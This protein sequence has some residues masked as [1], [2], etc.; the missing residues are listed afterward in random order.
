MREI[1]ND[2]RFN[3]QYCDDMIKKINHC[4]L[5]NYRPS[6]VT[7]FEIA[8]H[9]FKSCPMGYVKNAEYLQYIQDAQ[10][11]PFLSNIEELDFKRVS[12]AL[13][14]RGLGYAS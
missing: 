6:D 9:S 2:K 1:V 13:I 11:L 3:C 7:L 8:G 14:L 5:E 4:P 12:Y 10:S